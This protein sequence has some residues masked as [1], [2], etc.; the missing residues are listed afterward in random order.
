MTQG[1]LLSIWRRR[2]ILTIVTVMVAGL[3]GYVAAS[4]LPRT[5]QASSQVMLLASKSVAQQ[6]GAGNPYLSFSPS[7]TLTAD[8]VSRELISPA[9]ARQLSVRGYTASYT[10]ALAT[11]T[12]TTTGSVLQITVTGRHPSLVAA[13]LTA[14][15]RQVGAE[16]TQLQGKVKP[17]QQI[18]TVTLS[19]APPT[20]DVASWARNLIAV[21]AAAL[22]FVLGV[23]VLTDGLLLRQEPVGAR[24]AGRVPAPAPEPRPGAVPAAPDSH[25]DQIVLDRPPTPATPGPADTAVLASRPRRP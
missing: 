2:A 23:P 25:D 17:A 24:A 11:Y 20:L 8:A 12:T 21:I 3:G 15:T 1:G 9:V 18:R 4:Q 10:A 5:Y 16:L 19:T 13:T 6:A 22:V 14:V 7:L